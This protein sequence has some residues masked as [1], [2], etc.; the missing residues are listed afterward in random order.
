M[1]DCQDFIFSFRSLGATEVAESE[2]VQYWLY[3]A[4]DRWEEYR[5][6]GFIDL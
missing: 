5:D 6:R 4:E 1:V 3:R 2:K